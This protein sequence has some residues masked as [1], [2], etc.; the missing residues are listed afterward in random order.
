MKYISYN[1]IVF[2]YYMSIILVIASNINIIIAFLI[3]E[4]MKV[5]CIIYY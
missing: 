3:P 2:A 1:T 5:Y 4:F